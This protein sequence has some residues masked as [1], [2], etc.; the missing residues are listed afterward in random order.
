MRSVRLIACL[1]AIPRPT[2]Y[3]LLGPK[4]FDNVSPQI[5]PESRSDIPPFPGNLGPRAMD[6]LAGT[7]LPQY[8]RECTLPAPRSIPRRKCERTD[9]KGGGSPVRCRAVDGKVSGL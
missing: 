4:N 3:L 1:A 6:P 5:I 2:T 7:A 9:G 8:A